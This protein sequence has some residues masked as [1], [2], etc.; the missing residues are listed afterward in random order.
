MQNNLLL[1][2]KNPS[3][4]RGVFYLALFFIS[5]NSFS[6][7]I[8]KFKDTKKNFGFV[9]KG[10]LV[11]VK[12]EFTNVGNEPLLIFEYKVGCSCTEVEFSRDPVLPGKSDEIVVIFDTKTVYDRQDREVEIISNAKNK[13]QRIRFK[14]VVLNK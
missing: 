13:V 1:S 3:N 6:Q 10:E 2:F 4:F 11:K 7:P 12:F 14:G 8:L 9:K 5:L